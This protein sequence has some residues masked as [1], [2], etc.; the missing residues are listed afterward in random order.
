MGKPKILVNGFL[1]III[2]LGIP[3]GVKRDEIH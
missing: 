1:F 3:Y 2:I